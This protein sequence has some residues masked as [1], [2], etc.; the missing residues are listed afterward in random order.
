MSDNLQHRF[1][2]PTPP[3]FCVLRAEIGVSHL[4]DPWN[5]LER[6]SLSVTFRSHGNM[7]GLSP[8]LTLWPDNTRAEIVARAGATRTAEKQMI[9]IVEGPHQ[10]DGFFAAE[11]VSRHSLTGLYRKV[12]SGTIIWHFQVVPHV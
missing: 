9:Y 5:I 10:S 8:F 2:W 11:H 1:D 7:F 12:T 4:C 6:Q 3:S